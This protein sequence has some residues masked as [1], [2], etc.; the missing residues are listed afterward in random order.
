MARRMLTAVGRELN[1]LRQRHGKVVIE[2][3][4]QDWQKAKGRSGSDSPAECRN[5]QAEE[6]EE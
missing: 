4:L 3:S 5:A 2:P 1:L 6:G